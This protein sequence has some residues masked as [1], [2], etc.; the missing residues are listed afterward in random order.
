MAPLPES[1]LP[2]S[3]VFDS[4]AVDLFGPIWIKD[5]VKKRSRGKCWGVLFCCTVTSAIHLEISEDYSCDSFLLCLRRF[6]NLRGIPSRFQSDPG[7]QLLAAAVELGKWDFSNVIEWAKG[8]TIEWHKIPVNSQHYNGVAES[9]IRVTKRQL[10]ILLGEQ[11][12]T[13][14]HRDNIILLGIIIILHC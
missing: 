12:L 8:K 5:T 4:T 10:G 7:D 11:V 2:P 13:K 14:G 6:V 1:R 3:P 9:M